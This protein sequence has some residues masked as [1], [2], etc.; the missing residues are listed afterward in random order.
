MPVALLVNVNA[1]GGSL[2]AELLDNQDNP[3]PGYTIDD[4]LPVQSDETSHRVQWRDHEKL[5][6]ISE[7]II[8]KFELTNASLFGFYAGPEVVRLKISK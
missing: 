3:I 5:P 6:D 7:P 8:I 1:K 4:C 2:R